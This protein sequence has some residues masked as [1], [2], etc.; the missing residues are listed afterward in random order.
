MRI[1]PHRRSGRL[2]LRLVTFL[3]V[4][5]LGVL[6]RTCRMEVIEG[7]E[8]IDRLVETGEPVILAFWH[9]R[10]I[11]G[12]NFLIKALVLAGYPMVLVASRSRDGE[13]V[14]RFAGAHGVGSVRGSSSRGGRAVLSGAYRALVKD[15]VAPI[16]IPDG[17]RGPAYQLKPGTV[18]ISQM[19]GA[20][21]LPMGFAARKSWIIGSWDRLIFPRPFSRVAVAVG[22]PVTVPRELSSE[23]R[24]AAR[25]RCQDE[26]DRVTREAE[27]AVG[28]SDPLR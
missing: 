3:L 8:R 20:A 16:I 27:A 21:I 13:L 11:L 18:A 25:R 7:A 22:E 28:V 10:A 5:V 9:N 15:R 4:A 12:A 26:I 14:A 1:D 17:P 23:E 6:R 2:L 19:A 24:E